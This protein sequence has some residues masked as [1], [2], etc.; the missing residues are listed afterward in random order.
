MRQSSVHSKPEH[1]ICPYCSG[2]L[3][4]GNGS[5]IGHYRKEYVIK[6]FWYCGNKEHDLAYVGCHKDTAIPLGF[7]ANF[8]LRQ[9]KVDA[10]KA[11]NSLWSGKT[12]H[13][14]RKQAYIW[15]AD[16]LNVP[17]NECHIGW[18]KSVKC[19]LVVDLISDYWFNKET[20]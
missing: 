1:Y 11:F 14:T 3:T 12:A 2:Q 19:Q 17:A 10:H 9:L 6:A 20:L 15:L 16:K 7:V 13:M 5:T 18:F 8:N 4:L